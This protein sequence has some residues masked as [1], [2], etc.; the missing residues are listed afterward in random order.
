VLGID[1]AFGDPIRIGPEHPH[2]AAISA[3]ALNLRDAGYVLNEDLSWQNRFHQS[4]K[5]AQQGGVRMV[6]AQ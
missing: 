6:D 4:R 5:G 3:E 1:N 2:E